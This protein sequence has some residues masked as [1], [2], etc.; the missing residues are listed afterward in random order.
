ML[1]LN[2]KEVTV[3]N[4]KKAIE[5][6]IGKTSGTFK[7]EL[8]YV[9]TKY[10]TPV[11]DEAIV[12]TPEIN[13]T[14]DKNDLY[15]DVTLKPDVGH[16]TDQVTML[17]K[18]LSALSAGGVFNKGA[19]KK[20]LDN[21]GSKTPIQKFLLQGTFMSEVQD[22][23]LSL[24]FYEPKVRRQ[25]FKVNGVQYW[26][27]EITEEFYDE[28]SGK[29]LFTHTLHSLF[30]EKT[31]DLENFFS[32]LVGEEL[33]KRDATRVLSLLSYENV[34]G[35]QIGGYQIKDTKHENLL[36]TSYATVEDIQLR[37]VGDSYSLRSGGT[38]TTFKGT[39][40]TKLMVERT[41]NGK[42]TV[43]LFVD[44][45]VISLFLG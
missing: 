19:F 28:K 30:K 10:Q 29:V 18:V 39:A 7:N 11:I 45:H 32:E 17:D 3:S 36:T 1:D 31:S 41:G 27:Y 15:V 40:L 37:E 20:E 2:K 9:G 21:Q 23:T 22:Y 35:F 16:Q 13:L 38:D 42:Y 5:A 26:L 14:T 34:T 25:E 8:S 33:N 4:F 6:S 44:N 12:A 43:G 24:I